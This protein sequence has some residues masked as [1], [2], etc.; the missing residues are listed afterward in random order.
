MSKNGKLLKITEVCEM[1]GVSKPM[2]YDFI[3]DAENPL[4]VIRL[5]E[6]IVRIRKKDLDVPQVVNG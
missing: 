5:S 1:L 2:V 4:P 6:R 3:K